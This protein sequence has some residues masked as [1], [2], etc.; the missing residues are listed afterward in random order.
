MS[1][2]LLQRIKMLQL[3]EKYLQRKGNSSLCVID[4]LNRKTDLVILYFD[5]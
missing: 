3:I 4:H 5:Q 1:G 2:N